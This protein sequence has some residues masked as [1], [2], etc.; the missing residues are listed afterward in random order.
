MLPIKKTRAAVLVESRKPLVI[1]DINLPKELKSGQ[2]LVR[3]ITSGIC[4]A[5]INEVDAVKG[6][7]NFLPHLLGHEG[8]AEVLAISDITSKVKVGDFVILHWRPGSGIQS[9]TPFYTS[10]NIEIN[11]GWV[12]TFN[13]H[14]IVSENRITKIEVNFNEL[15]MPLLGCA[16]TTAWGVL[17][18]EAKLLEGDN[19]LI[20]GSGGV[21]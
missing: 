17:E 9:E 15:L 19:L 11:A 16:L 7:D 6:P 13:E 18:N 10:G 5:Q 4:G 2:V 12:T 21:G 20:F 14:A 8:L 3:L 1:M